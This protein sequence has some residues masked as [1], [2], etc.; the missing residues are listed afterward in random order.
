LKVTE[1]Q[2]G[3]MRGMALECKRKINCKKSC[4]V[5]EG[6]FEGEDLMYFVVHVNI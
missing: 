3:R 6:Q 2:D 5:R 4:E 1:R